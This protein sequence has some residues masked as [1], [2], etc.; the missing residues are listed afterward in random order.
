MDEWSRPRLF[1]LM[2]EETR[3]WQRIALIMG[4][5]GWNFDLPY[6]GTQSHLLA[7]QAEIEEMKQDYKY[8][9]KKLKA[10]GY[11]RIPLTGPKAGKPDGKLNEDY[12]E[13]ER[14]DGVIEYWINL[15]K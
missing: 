4:Y 9:A 1:P 11:K 6:W 15:N 13:V 12:I 3:T 5:S 7:E 8:N 14:W 10:Q 2:N